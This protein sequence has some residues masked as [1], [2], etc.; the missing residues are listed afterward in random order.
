M[1][2]LALLAARRPMG[3]TAR[4]NDPSRA[5]ILMQGRGGKAPELEISLCRGVIASSP[6]PLIPLILDHCSKDSD[7][8]LN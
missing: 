7:S 2:L 1:D 4:E 5:S 6:Q 3:A 8:N